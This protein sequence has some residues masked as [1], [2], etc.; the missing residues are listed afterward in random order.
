ML[1]VV[2][3]SLD[4]VFGSKSKSKRSY[5]VVRTEAGTDVIPR[6]PSRDVFIVEVGC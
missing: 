1:A 6:L 3:A 2:H 4:A 5:T